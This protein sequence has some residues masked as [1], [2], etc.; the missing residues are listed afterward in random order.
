[1]TADQLILHEVTPLTRRSDT[2]A[3]EADD[4][5]DR[6]ARHAEELRLLVDDFL[7][8]CNRR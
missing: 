6:H 5:R 3:R 7:V 4:E 1:M 2:S 8:T